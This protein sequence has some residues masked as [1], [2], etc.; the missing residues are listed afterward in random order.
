M[1][2]ISTSKILIK[3]LH[4]VLVIKVIKRINSVELELL[5]M[6]ITEWITHTSPMSNTKEV[7]NPPEL[8]DYHLTK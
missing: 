4:K 3:P 7:L 5:V 2:I 1:K 8:L 6:L